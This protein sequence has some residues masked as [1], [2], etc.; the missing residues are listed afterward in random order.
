MNKHK[1]NNKEIN[2][3]V[4]NPKDDEKN[5]RN[6]NF[7]DINLNSRKTE[8]IKMI[9]K[10]EE[11]KFVCHKDNDIKVIYYDK[12]TY[13]N[14]KNNNLKNQSKIPSYYKIKFKKLYFIFHLIISFMNMY[15][16]I[17]EY[18]KE[19]I[20]SKLSEVSLKIKGIG[21]VKLFSDE[22]F[23]KYNNC[24]IYLNDTF[25]DIKKNEYYIDSNLNYC[26]NISLIFIQNIKIIWNDTIL[27]TKNMFE[28]CDKIFEINLYNFDTSQIKDTS[29]MFNNCSSLILLNLSSFDTS[30][31]TDMSYMFYNCSSLTSLDVS[32]FNT[33]HLRNLIHIFSQ[34]SSLIS[35]DLTNFDTSNIKDMTSMFYN[36]SSLI[37]LNLSNFNTSQVTNMNN[38]FANCTK[39]ISLDLSSF[40]TSKVTHMSSMFINSTSLQYINLSNFETSNVITMANMFYRCSSLISL[41]LLNFNTSKVTSMYAMFLTCKTLKFLNLSNFNTSGVTNMHYMFHWCS[42]ITSLDLSNFNTSKVTGM[43]AM[44]YYCQKLTYLNISSFNTSIVTNMGSMF[45]GCSSLTSLD[46]SNFNTTKVTSMS[47]MFC[48]CK[49]TPLDLSNFNTSNVMSMA[50]MFVNSRF[51]S[52]NLSN[53]DTSKVTNMSHMFRNT[54]HGLLNISNFDTSNVINMSYMFSQCTYLVSLDLSN[55]NTSKATNMSLMFNQCTKLTTLNISNINTSKVVDMNRMF[56]NCNLM[57][58]LSLSNFDTSRVTDI[59]NMFYGCSGLTSLDLFNFDTSQVEKMNSMFYNCLK[60]YS[61]NIS[62]FNTSSVKDMNNMFSNCK[63]LSS[64]NL[65]NFN[66]S[67]VIRM[68][69]MFYNCINLSLLNLPNFDTSNVEYM[70]NM[71]Y[72]CYL[73]SSLDVSSFNLTKVQNLNNMFQGCKNLEYVN[74]YLPNIN[75]NSTTKG[76]FLSTPDNLVI[77]ADNDDYIFIDILPNSKKYQCHNSYSENKFICYMKNSSFFNKHICDICTKKLSTNYQELNDSNTTTS[78]YE[79]VDVYDSTELA[80]TSILTSENYQSSV[81]YS[82]EMIFD[83]IKNETIEEIIDNIIEEFNKKELDSGK[84]KKIVDKNKT[85]ILT[86]TINQK[87]NEEKNYITM[88]LGKCEDIFKYHY[89]ISDNDPLYILQIIAEEEGMKIPKVEYEVYY[90]FYNSSNLTKLNLSLCKDTKIEISIP[91]PIDGPLDKY[92][93]KSGYYNDICS[94]AT[95]DSG[96]DITL[97]DRQNEFVNNNMSLCEENCEL[98]EYNLEKEKAKCFC[99]IKLSIPPNYDIKFNKKDFFKS[100]ADIKNLFNLN[101]MKC[102]ETAITIKSLNKNYGFFIADSVIVL[103]FIS[104]IIFVSNSFTKIKKEIYIILFETKIHGN[105]IKKKQVKIKHKNKKRKVNKILKNN[106]TKVFTIKNSEIITIEMNN[107]KMTTYKPKLEKASSNSC[108]KL[109]AKQKIINKKKKYN[110][111]TIIQKDFELNSLDYLEAFSIDNRNYCQYYLSLLKRSHP[112]LFSFG[113]DNDYNSRIIKIFLFFFSLCL[114]LVVN[115]LFFTDDTMHKI[116]EDK[117]KFNF[118]YQIPQIIYSALISGFINS[119]IR[120]LALSQDIIAQLKIK[121]RNENS[122][123]KY[124]KLLRILKIKFILFFVL[125]FIILIFFIYYLTCFCGIYVNTQFYLIKDTLISLTASFIIPFVFCLIPGIFRIPSLKSRKPTRKL[126]YKFSI[127]I[128]NLFC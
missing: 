14:R 19:T 86:S 9:S 101:I 94:K 117:G 64:L 40:N 87:N 97:R 41:D 61:L 111:K 30:E 39:L 65:F 16:L 32:N 95:S 42:N 71:F 70:D 107:K 49:F 118:L 62:N 79:S 90:P 84:D 53:F 26:E 123:I 35:L 78:C 15:F 98:I 5:Q 127:I 77:C 3:K 46:L 34:C 6:V 12:S 54:I 92:N 58:S 60:L 7:K 113:C 72:N 21:N 4:I 24:E 68:N 13:Q 125:A 63:A 121:K 85:I 112:I 44:F 18:N 52:L 10:E 59:S 66:T 69:N 120:N 83:F 25:F 80:L 73:I 110:S 28:N 50:G 31:V 37:S 89:N 36:C 106:N 45:C 105:P 103:Y 108:Y 76:I 122:K 109:N 51:T 56:Y 126:L 91:V 99:D 96:T 2:R 67:K 33:S 17:C 115:A 22:F 29:R 102:Y 82:S 57:K 43:Y 88:D 119:F 100:F 8:I 11:E 1:L 20:L 38:L 124:V 23:R 27:T 55:F 104:L 81:S 116:Y 114:D 128:E 75:P 93:P 48:G 74:L 47:Y